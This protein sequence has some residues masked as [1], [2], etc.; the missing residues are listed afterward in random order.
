ML[1]SS[2]NSPTPHKPLRMLVFIPDA[3]TAGVHKV[4]AWAIMTATFVVVR[5]CHTV[6]HHTESILQ[7]EI[8]LIITSGQD[9]K[10]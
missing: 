3:T 10:T 9:S 7:S 2:Q 6:L 1:G 8:S 4:V 5:L